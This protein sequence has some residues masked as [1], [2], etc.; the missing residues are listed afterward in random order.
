MCLAA[1][2]RESGDVLRTHV[3][4]CSTWNLEYCFGS[5]HT[6]L[7]GMGP[8]CA[9]ES[10]LDSKQSPQVLCVGATLAPSWVPHGQG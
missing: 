7:H 2:I 6:V 4:S 10:L 9:L 1:N 5:L 3:T 8:L